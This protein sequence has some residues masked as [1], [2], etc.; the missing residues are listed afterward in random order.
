MNPKNRSLTL[1]AALMA[2][3]SVGAA[4][5]AKPQTV[6]A[7]VTSAD[8]SRLLARQ[9][10]VAFKAKQQAL[11]V[12]IDVDP[13]QRFQTMVGFGASITDA[14]A[15]LIQQRMSEAQRKALLSEL[16]GRGPGGI[17]FDFARLTIGASDFSRAHY[18]FNDLPAGQTDIALKGFSI[19]PNRLD[20]LP[21]IKAALAINPGLQVM[22]SPW[23]APGWMK[24]GDSLVKGSLKPEMYG[25]FSDY[26]LRYVDAYAAE[27]VPIFALTLQNEPHFE[28]DDYPGM[29]VDP[30]ARAAVI[31]QHLGPLLAKRENEQKRKTK[32]F[33]WD[34]NW[35][36]AESPLAVLADPVARP[37]VAGVAWHCYAGDV[38][39]QTLVHDA[40]PDK[41]VWFTECS[42]GEW[43]PE[44]RKT[45]PWMMSNLV[46]GGTRGWAK[47]VLMWNLALDENYGPHLG[48]CKDCRGVVTINSKTGA[49]TRNIEYYALA[50][51]SKFVRAG[52]QR[53]ASTAAVAGLE[54]VAFR[55]AD[56]GSVALIVSNGSAQAKRFSVAAGGQKNFVYVLPR[57]SVATFT[58]PGRP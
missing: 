55:N 38:A 14:S 42:G 30:A 17:G 39:A 46:I 27:G 25:V 2:L 26:L 53:I 7:W 43:A 18:S 47:G 21:V 48:G 4:A 49:V 41:E 8:Q 33:D 34:H 6:S 15:W 56:D 44:W 31:G 50:H 32:L 24:S 12:H 5:P 45:L 1:L 29:R 36:Q 11:D 13:A 9:D 54:T 22:A 20:V 16:F 37:F 10:D 57:E 40:H 23:S 51:A 19:E 28:P 35:D 58:W 52:A 3:A